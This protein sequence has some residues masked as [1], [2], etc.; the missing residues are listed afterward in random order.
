[1]R[2]KLKL[3]VDSLDMQKLQTTLILDISNKNAYKMHINPFIQIDMFHQL[4][5]EI[6]KY[7]NDSNIFV[8][9]FILKTDV[10]KT[11]DLVYNEN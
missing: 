10:L 5:G 4:H 2:W 3:H 9:H 11:R 6:L 7:Y 1:M 8:K